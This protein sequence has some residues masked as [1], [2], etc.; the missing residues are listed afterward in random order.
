MEP[1]SGAV[2]GTFAMY[3]GEPAEPASVELKAIQLAAQMTGIAIER[4]SAQQ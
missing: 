3:Y 2:L 4:V 1:P